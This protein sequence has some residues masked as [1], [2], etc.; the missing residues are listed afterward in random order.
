MK[1]RRAVR[2]PAPVEPLE[3]RRLLS[4]TYTVVPIGYDAPGG[5][6]SNGIVALYGAGKTGGQD[7][8]LW[9]DGTLTDLGT[10]LDGAYAGGVNSSGDV[11][12]YGEAG[13]GVDHAFVY[14]NGTFNAIP[15][16]GGS[17]VTSYDN[18]AAAINDAGVI[19]GNSSVSTG[20]QQ[21]FVT[22]VG[23]GTPTDI[24][25]LDPTDAE[26]MS[27]ADAVNA[28]GTV[29][30]YSNVSVY[31]G[32][33]VSYAGGALTGYGNLPNGN[34][35]EAYAISDNGIIVG[36]AASAG[37]GES[38]TPAYPHA[39]EVEGGPWSTW[40]RW[41][42]PTRRAMRTASTTAGTSSVKPTSTP[43]ATSAPSSTPVGRWST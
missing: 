34:G 24:G 41:P 20:G 42:A 19:V 14:A 43:R 32:V 37:A 7:A 36:T 15:P 35:S 18:Y 39:V 25:T 13:G 3:D 33:A 5:L 4:V 38:G 27:G 1:A 6:S 9:H 2:Q 29:V 26:P 11:V 12:G 40:D 30:G 16:L 28:A 8:L 10:Y 17:S 23:G 31:A 22:T 21:G